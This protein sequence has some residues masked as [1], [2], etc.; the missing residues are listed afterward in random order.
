MQHTSGVVHVAER[1]RSAGQ[2]RRIVSREN[3]SIARR[4]R[5]AVNGNVVR[6]LRVGVHAVHVL[7][8][9]SVSSAALHVGYVPG[10]EVGAREYGGAGGG[11]HGGHGS[12]GEAHG[13]CFVVEVGSLLVCVCVC[14]WV[15]VGN[16][17]AW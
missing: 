14:E 17:C 16:D 10:A 2:G 3:L 12:D 13:D 15:R 8:V 11:G 5:E 7:R 1:R 4:L 9:C 6:E